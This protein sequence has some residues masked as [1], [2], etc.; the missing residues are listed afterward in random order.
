MKRLDN[1]DT[2]PLKNNGQTK[3][4]HIRCGWNNGR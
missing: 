4:N 3:S 2:A 1:F